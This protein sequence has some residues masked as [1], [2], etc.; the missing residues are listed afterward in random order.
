MTDTRDTDSLRSA[1]EDHAPGGSIEIL[2]VTGLPEFRPGDDLAATVAD[3]APWLRDGDILIVTSKIISK[4]E[5]RLVQAPRDADERDAARRV[6]VEQE[7][8]RIVARKGR[9]LI[10][11]N[12]LGIVQAASGI[13]GS[14]VDGGELALLPEN[15]DASA[16]ALRTALGALLGVTVAVV[17]TDTMGRAWRI[18]QTDAAIGAAGLGVV[19][20][21]AGAEDGQG[22]ELV[23]TEVAIA[24]ELAAAGDLVKG[25][26]GGVPIAV[27]RG[28]TPVDDGSTAATLL[29]GGEDDL[30]W[31]GT[32][33]ALDR[34][35]RE[36]LLRRRSVRS[37]TDEPVDPDAV[38][39]AVADALTAPAPHHTRPVRFVWVRTPAVRRRLLETMREQWR[40]DL[41]GDGLSEERIAARLSRGDILFD[42]PEIVIPFC[43]PDGAHSYPDERRRTAE[44]TMFTVAVG[45]A[46]Q[47]LLVALAVRELGS[48][49]IGS[50][51]F[52]ADTVRAELGLRAD[53]KAM[54]AIAIGHPSESLTVRDP[55]VPGSSLVEL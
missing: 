30:F 44:D 46:V 21:Y 47:G 38:R 28:L 55:V 14:N 2:P 4:V 35:R 8:V 22:N 27:V 43:V 48:C 7:A 24:D 16:A 33:E 3:R 51:I 34:G 19:H 37:F 9:T 54:G 23:V 20:A 10:T 18:G 1:P 42:A 31:L 53:W 12:R 13:D 26:L 32:A 41:A 17:V 29:R 15:P 5:G 49:W 25:K 36:A 39:A 52:A 45:A 40:A 50:T 6:L 11:E